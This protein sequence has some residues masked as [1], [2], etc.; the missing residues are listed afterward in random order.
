MSS[1]KARFDLKPESTA[2]TVVK[3]IPDGYHSLTAYLVVQG[4]AN[5]IQFYQKAFG[6]REAFRLDGPDGR[7]GHAELRIGDSRLMISDGCDQGPLASPESRPP[8]SM[9]LYIENADTVFK[10][11]VEVGAVEVAPVKDQFYGDWMGTL[12][13]PYG[14][15]WFIATHIEELSHEQ[16]KARA[17]EMWSE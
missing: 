15:V 17:R 9:H 13:D 11:A 2:D 7:V 16:I 3:P 1:G 14:H 10:R 6:F 4:A 12:R 8:S 5:A